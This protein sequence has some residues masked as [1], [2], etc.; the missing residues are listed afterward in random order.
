MD[1]LW[2]RHQWNVYWLSIILSQN[3]VTFHWAHNFMD[4]QFRLN[5]AGSSGLNW[6]ASFICEILLISEGSAQTTKFTQL[7]STYLILQQSSPAFFMWLRQ[8][9]WNTEQKHTRLLEAYAQNRHV[10]TLT[11][12]YWPKEATMPTQIPGKRTRPHF[13]MGGAL[14]SHCKR[15]GYW[16]EWRTV[17]LFLIYHRKL[18]LKWQ[19]ITCYYTWQHGWISSIM[20]SEIN[21]AEKNTHRIILF[22]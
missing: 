10:V 1:Q 22:I 3:V 20:L 18:W 15:H 21:Q 12:F 19:T 9:F 17:S 8:E 7:C 11:M 14:K 6:A 4:Q 13:F 5:S 2:Y 16:K